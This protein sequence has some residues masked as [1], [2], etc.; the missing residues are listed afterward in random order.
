MADQKTAG[1]GPPRQRGTADGL[2]QRNPPTLSEFGV[3]GGTLLEIE[4]APG[5][6]LIRLHGSLDLS[7]AEKI[8]E[9]QLCAAMERTAEV[10]LDLTGLTDARPE[11]LKLFLERQRNGLRAARRLSIRIDPTQVSE[12]YPQT[13]S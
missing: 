10:C 5:E 12:F 6:T 7:A 8:D 1:P 4:S 11:A 2:E 9:Q 3:C 13:S